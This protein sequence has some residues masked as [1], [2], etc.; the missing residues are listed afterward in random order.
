MASRFEEAAAPE[1]AAWPNEASSWKRPQRWSAHH[2]R[3]RPQVFGPTAISEETPVRQLDLNCDL[4]PAREEAEFRTLASE[5]N[6]SGAGAAGPVPRRARRRG[7]KSPDRSTAPRLQA[8]PTPSPNGRPWPQSPARSRR[9]ERPGRFL[10]PTTAGRV[11][12]SGLPSHFFSSRPVR[13]QDRSLP[14]P[15]APNAHAPPPFPAP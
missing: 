10:D 4:R 2:P 8:P 11:Q 3:R 5:Q 15:A 12:R 13:Q 9:Q 6:S 7:R 1:C 14:Q